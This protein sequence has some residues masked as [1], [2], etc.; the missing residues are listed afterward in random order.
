[1]EAYLIWVIK[2]LNDFYP[3]SFR[4][5]QVSFS[6]RIP[7]AFPLGYAISMLT[8]VSLYNTG[9]SPLNFREM[10][11][12]VKRNENISCSSETI[13][14]LIYIQVCRSSP[15]NKKLMKTMK[16]M[17]VMK[18]KR[19]GKKMVTISQRAVARMT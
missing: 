10:V 2:W 19:K 4:Q 14:K 12:S 3:E 13:D 11:K 9:A 7:G 1:M 6:T 5:A 17:T 16:I 15:R 8:M 18:T